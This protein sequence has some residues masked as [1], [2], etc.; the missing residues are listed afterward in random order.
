MKKN[1]FNNQPYKTSDLKTWGRIKEITT[2][3]WH[4]RTNWPLKK[5]TQ[6]YFLNEDIK[7]WVIYSKPIES[8]HN[9]VITWIGHS[10][11]LIQIGG[12]NILTDPA[13]SDLNFL[14]PR[15]CTPGI[16]L[17]NLPK[18]DFVLISHNHNDHMEKQSLF[19]L[20]K[21]HPTF[22][23]PKGIKN[24]FDE[25]RFYN[26]YE[27][28]WW[29]EQILSI[30]YS[31]TNKIKFTFLP[32]IH[33]SGT[34]PFN[35]NK[36]FWGSFMIEYQNFKIYFAGDTAYAPHFQE[37]AQKFNNINLALMPVS[38]NG[39]QEIM[40]NSHVDA[41]QAIQAFIDLKAKNFV[42]MHWGTYRLATDKFSEPIEKL[43]QAWQTKKVA[44]VDKNLHVL[45]FGQ[46]LLLD[47]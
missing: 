13:F 47:F 9:P 1:L 35:I 33:W 30:R 16:T 11:F 12:T 20:K 5:N 38:P 29:Q 34:N 19:A 36:T 44:L 25:N 14:Y 26:V 7:N 43:Q 3:F 23:V 32:A 18:I 10:T 24:W 46:Q 39:S 2:A 4:S 41:Q 22:L 31:K 42:P 8:S 6:N 45:K 40:D 17:Q 21:H 15:N 37:I 28:E 27:H